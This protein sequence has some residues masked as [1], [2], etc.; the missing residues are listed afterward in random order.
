MTAH[1]TQPPSDAARRSPAASEALELLDAKQVGSLFGLRPK[2]VLSLARD[3][4]LPHIKLGKYTR[5][6]RAA[7]E[8]WLDA[9]E[10]KF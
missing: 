4:G 1:S 6:R 5:F 9:N 7:V 10:V 3:R 2:Y 8:A